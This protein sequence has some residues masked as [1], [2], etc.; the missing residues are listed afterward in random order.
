M[1]KDKWIQSA[2]KKPGALC[3]S[4]H[5]KEGRKIPA[6]KLEKATHSKNSTTRKRA[7]LAKTLKRLHNK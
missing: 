3:K 1:A 2:I 5:V 6:E 7:L 4:L